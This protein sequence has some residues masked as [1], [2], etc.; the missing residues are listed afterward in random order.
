MWEVARR[1]VASQP[2]CRSPGYFGT[3]LCNSTTASHRR[4]YRCR[5]QAIACNLASDLR[6]FRDLQGAATPLLRGAATTWD[7]LIPDNQVCSKRW[8]S[9]CQ[10][11]RISCWLCSSAWR[12][13]SRWSYSTTAG[14]SSSFSINAVRLSCSS[15]RFPPFSRHICSTRWCWWSWVWFK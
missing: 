12:R 1:I 15:C 2:N 4:R 10:S 13:N 8:C 14:C 3:T 6:W 7:W 11:R 5:S 9:S